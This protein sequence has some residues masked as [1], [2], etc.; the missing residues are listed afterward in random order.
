MSEL[1]AAITVEVVS[2]LL[3]SLIV[4]A[5]RRLVSRPA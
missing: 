3:V 2:V 4:A 1:L 5:C